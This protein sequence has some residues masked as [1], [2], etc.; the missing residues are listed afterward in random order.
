MK[1]ASASQIIDVFR[2]KMQI[3]DVIDDLIQ[4]GR[5]MAIAVAARIAG[6]K[7]HRRSTRFVG[8]LAFK[9]TLHHGQ[10]I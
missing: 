10:F 4:T 1:N 8:I 9:V 7:K 6:G 2:I 3:L 5:Q